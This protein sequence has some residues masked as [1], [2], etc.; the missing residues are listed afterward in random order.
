M[1]VAPIVQTIAERERLEQEEEARYEKEK[2]RLKERKVGSLH[3]SNRSLL[4]LQNAASG[5]DSTMLPA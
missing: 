4:C 2:D 5:T 1:L 3:S